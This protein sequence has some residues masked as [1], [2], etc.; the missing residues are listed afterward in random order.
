[1]WRLD[2]MRNVP[3]RGK[4]TRTGTQHAVPTRADVLCFAKP[5]STFD[6]HSADR[7][8]RASNDSARQRR[9]RAVQAALGIWRRSCSNVVLLAVP[10]NSGLHMHN[11]FQLKLQFKPKLHLSRARLDY[12]MTVCHA[13][14]IFLS[15]P[16]SHPTAQRSHTTK[17]TCTWQ[18]TSQLKLPFAWRLIDW[19]LLNINFSQAYECT[20]RLQQKSWSTSLQI[21][22]WPRK[23]KSWSLNLWFT[24]YN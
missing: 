16:K 2:S 11:E 12:A 6:I 13:R 5:S 17:T 8:R 15:L 3:N 22:L 1:M 14:S 18:T 20:E 19:K 10:P 4:R 24:L 23:Y 7:G 21:E 9:C